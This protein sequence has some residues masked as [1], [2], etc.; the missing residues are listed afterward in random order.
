VT[1]HARAENGVALTTLTQTYANPY[2]EPLEVHYTLPLPADGATLGFTMTLGTRTIT[3]EVHS[4]EEAARIY[5]R[6]IEAGHAAALMQQHRADTFTQQ[7]GNLP[8]GTEAT[9]EIHVLH[10][11]AFTPNKEWEYRFPTVV[12]VRYHGEPGRVE[13]SKK[14]DPDRADEDGT[15]VRA[16]FELRVDGEK[17][18]EKH[19]LRLDRDI[20]ERWRAVEADVAARIVEG[21]GLEGDA[22]RYALVTVT[23]PEEP[24]EVA[25]RD[26]TI[27]I[28]A[29]GSMTGRPLESAKEITARILESLRDEDRF[30]LLAFSLAIPLRAFDYPL[31]ET[32]VKSPPKS[33][34]F[35]RS[36]RTPGI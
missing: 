35:S 9:I 19:D 1:I 26:L 20:V 10:P 36:A 32:F 29:S 28:D 27:L 21:R 2:D 12:G 30:E 3:S 13:D 15:P 16:S 33:P 24:K 31:T 6:A 25:P 11:L 14:L 17:K 34:A 8:P 7:L 23:P 18:F 5:D 4:A 22:G